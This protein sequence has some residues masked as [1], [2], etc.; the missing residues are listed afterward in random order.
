MTTKRKPGTNLEDFY[1]ANPKVAEMMG[2]DGV[3]SHYKAL[4]RLNEERRNLDRQAR[5]IDNILLGLLVS[6][7][8]LF[9][10][11]LFF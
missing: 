9:T 8:L 10:S 4:G 11:F 2:V 6:M 5:V 3:R 1:A 7:A